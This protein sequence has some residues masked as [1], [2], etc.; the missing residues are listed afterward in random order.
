SKRE[1]DRGFSPGGLWVK[2]TSV[3]QLLLRDVHK[4]Q[5]SDTEPEKRE[6]KER[7]EKEERE[8]REELL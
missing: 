5:T 3:L 1:A 2:V 4:S 8:D 6:R 7:E